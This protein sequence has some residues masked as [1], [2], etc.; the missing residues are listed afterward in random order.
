MVTVNSYGKE[1][2]SNISRSFWDGGRER[3]RRERS[4]LLN[5][6]QYKIQFK[7]ESQYTYSPRKETC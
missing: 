3:E 5:T 1:D 2:F 7:I 6:R 4:L